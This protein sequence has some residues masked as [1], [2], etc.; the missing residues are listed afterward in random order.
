MRGVYPRRLA[1]PCQDFFGVTEAAEATWFSVCDGHGSRGHEC[2]EFA[3]DQV[4]RVAAELLRQAPDLAVDVLMTRA[5]EATNALMHEELATAES[6]TTC[7]S[8]LALGTTLYCAN[9]GDSRCILGTRDRASGCLRPT[10][11]SVD[12]TLYRADERA[13]VLGAGGRVLS[14]GQIE[15][16]VPLDKVW[17]CDLGTELDEDGD[18]P[19]I[20][21]KDSYRPGCAFSRSL[22]D[23]TA[24]AVGCI[25][26]PE[27]SVH[28]LSEDDEIAIIASDGVWELLT[29]QD[30][31]DL[32]AASGPDPLAAAYSVVAAA[33]REWFDREGR[34]DDIS[35]VVIFFDRATRGNRAA[36]ARARPTPTPPRQNR[37]IAPRAS[38]D[39]GERGT[40]SGAKAPPG[41]ET[42]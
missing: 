24:E 11:L 40:P 15:G 16:T 41:P 13:R 19:R 36:R 6:G 27:V 8:L 10:P 20:W 21:L 7:V 42:D 1:K 18:P 5:L 12:Q 17:E 31:L 39:Y 4:E 3:R 29:D 23:R 35:I 14:I 38:V 30:V 26:T 22:G 28:A 33:Y 37:A 9:V 2:A 25:A 32:C 34:V